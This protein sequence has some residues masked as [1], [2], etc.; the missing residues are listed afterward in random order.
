MKE[1]I[2]KLLDDRK[3]RNDNAKLAYHILL[4]TQQLNK[5]QKLKRAL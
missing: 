4:L 1:K 2:M 5:K 3:L